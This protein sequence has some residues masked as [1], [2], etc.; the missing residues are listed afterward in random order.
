MAPEE[1]TNE[2]ATINIELFNEKPI[3][4]AAQPE[5]EFNMETTTG[6]SAPPIGMMIKTPKMNAITTITMK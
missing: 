1:P 6:M 3:P 2:P 4:A 5:Y